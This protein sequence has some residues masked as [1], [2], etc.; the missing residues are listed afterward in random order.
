MD[1]SIGDPLSENRKATEPEASP[2][3]CELRPCGVVSSS[4]PQAKRLKQSR[5]WLILP[6]VICFVQGLSHACLSALGLTEGL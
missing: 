3:R 6:A 2:T 1:W 4:Q 5:I